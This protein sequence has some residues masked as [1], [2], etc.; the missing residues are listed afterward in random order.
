SSVPATLPATFF[1]PLRMPMST[2]LFCFFP[3]R[4]CLLVMGLDLPRQADPAARFEAVA[5]G[6]REVPAGAR[7]VGVDAALVARASG[8]R[9]AAIAVA[10][11][12]DVGLAPHDELGVAAHDRVAPPDG[13]RV[14]GRAAAGGAALAVERGL[15]AL[16]G[17][18]VGLD[19]GPVLPAARPGAPGAR[20]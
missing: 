2:P 4:R 5:A 17:D 7:P 12:L 20:A 11:Q 18:R 13:D 9:R 16:A 19:P 3:G 10:A 15:P 6:A 14:V 8:Q 1:T